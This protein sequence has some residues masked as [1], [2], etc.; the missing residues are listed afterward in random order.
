ML[1][2]DLFFSLQFQLQCLRASVAVAN[3]AA[4]AAT[5]QAKKKAMLFIILL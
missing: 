1:V 3:R 4:A 2:T 5:Q